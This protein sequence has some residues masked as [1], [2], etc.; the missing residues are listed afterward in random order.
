VTAVDW[1]RAL[2]PHLPE[3]GGQDWA[4]LGDLERELVDQLPG[5]PADPAARSGWLL[6][7]RAHLA[8][9]AASPGRGPVPRA[10][11]QAL[12]QA[13]C[14]FYDLD[15]RDATGPGHGALI[16]AG[17]APSL[18]R[19][20]AA[21]LAA[22]DLVGI[23]ATERHGGSR[24]QEMT[25]RAILH[26]DR[27]LLSG[28]KCWVSRLVESAGWVVFF[29]DPD[30]RISAAVLDATAPGL[31]REPVTP[32]GLGG[33][34]WGILRLHDVPIDPGRDLLAGP[35]RGLELFRQ[36][37]TRFRPLVTATALGTA[38][39][40][41]ATVA[42]MLGARVRLGLLP[43]VRDNALIS[44][45]RTHA[46]LHAALLATLGTARLA[47]LGHPDAD[48]WA[49]LGK[50][51]GVDVAYQAVGELVPL[52]G[53]V[54]FQAGHPLAKA[55]GDLAGLLYADGIHDSLY[56]S[57]GTTILAGDR[58]AEVVPLHRPAVPVRA[59]VAA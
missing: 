58:P 23:A 14:G 38:A 31:E 40:V 55:R 17:G 37:F 25:A 6:G 57:G 51:Q 48:L 26:R 49:R 4:L 44:L 41:H 1:L 43:R 7:V 47:A 56:R 18:R 39:G 32:A 22:G 45:G 53:A 15:L 34:G 12:A 59:P 46:Q 10:L 35:G 2:A 42:A 21:R 36:H 9:R 28:E 19:R 3:L 13:V 33:W 29:R 16:L 20:W 50:A 11:R 30:G 8:Q 24:I 54:G 52:V 5:A 27:W